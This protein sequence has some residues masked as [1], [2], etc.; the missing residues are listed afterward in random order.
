VSRPE[1][2]AKKNERNTALSNLK[3]KE[4]EGKPV[5]PARKILKQ[6][7]PVDEGYQADSTD[8]IDVAIDLRRKNGVMV[9][10]EAEA[11]K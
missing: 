11:R 5:T 10:S 4:M 3:Q 1:V 2:Q 8:P 6:F 7:K 9:I